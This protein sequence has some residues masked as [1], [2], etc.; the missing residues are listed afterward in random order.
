MNVTKGSVPAFAQYMAASELMLLS[1]F[2]QNQTCF[3]TTHSGTIKTCD[4][5][6]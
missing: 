5:L 1:H 4:V 6:R 2:H 3:Q